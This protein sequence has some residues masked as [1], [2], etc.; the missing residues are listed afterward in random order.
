VNNSYTIIW[1]ILLLAASAFFSASET[2]LF[3]LSKLQ[4][5]KLEN[6]NKK[7]DKR[8]LQLLSQPRMLLI[9]ILLANTLV[10]ITFSS[11]AAVYSLYLNQKLN[12]NLNDSIIITAQII[13]TTIIILLLGEIIPKLIAWSKAYLITTVVTVPLKILE[14]LLW[15]V[16]KLL[17]IF[18]KL[19]SKQKDGAGEAAITQEE[20]QTLI[21]S[22]APMHNLEEH[23]KKILAGLFRLPKTE[24]REII[25]PRVQIVAIDENRSID[26]LKEVITESGYSR[27]PVYRGSIDEITGI[28]YAKDIILHPEIKTI[29]EIM[30][31]PW[32]VT[33]NM[34]IQT[35]LNQFRSR[36]IQIAIVVDEYG[37]T[38]G[39]ITLEDIMEELVGEIQDEYDEDEAPAMERLENGSI[40]VNGTFGIR[41]LNNELE[42]NIDPDKYDNLADLL[43]EYFNSVPPVNAKMKIEN[44]VEFTILDSDKKRINK[45]RI[46]FLPEEENNP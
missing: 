15:P 12:I 5:K 28:A 46:D 22:N 27:I 13:V 36:K 35:L 38:S 17:E 9:T 4:L 32:F 45:V 1:L 33:E 37:G 34:K 44:K 6:S 42:L 11:F 23:E 41:E 18:S 21:H 30:R 14:V 10:N 7:I 31:K 8:I 19:I 3:S 39:L 43:L 29:K 40:I 25:I 16:I 24:I 20:F 26:E 2:A